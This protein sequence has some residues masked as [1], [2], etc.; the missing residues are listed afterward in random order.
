[1]THPVQLH[2]GKKKSMIFCGGKKDCCDL[3]GLIRTPTV[4]GGG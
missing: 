4:V 3:G 2:T 1:M